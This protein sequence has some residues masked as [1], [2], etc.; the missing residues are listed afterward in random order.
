MNFEYPSSL[1]TPAPGTR[2]ADITGETY[3]LLKS[4]CSSRANNEKCLKSRNAY[5][6]PRVEATKTPKLGGF[7]RSEISQQAKSFDSQMQRLQSFVLDSVAPLM[8][9]METYAKGETVSH[10]QAVTAATAA[11]ELVVN[12]SAQLSHYRRTRII[13]GMSK[14]LLPLVEDDKHFTEAVPFLFGPDFAQKSK[15]LIDQVKAMRSSVRDTKPSGHFFR[16]IPV[17][18]IS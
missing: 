1:D 13:T 2:V 4:N 12:T 10:K 9:I 18:I 16:T 5:S 17:L 14:T 11:I 3:L 7:V 6:L 15:D 8:A